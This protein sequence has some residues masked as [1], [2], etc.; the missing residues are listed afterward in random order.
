MR[1]AVLA[2]LLVFLWVMRIE[3]SPLEAGP[4]GHEFPLTLEDGRRI[5]AAGPLLSYEE[6]DRWVQWALSPFFSYRRDTVLDAEEFDVLYPLLTVDRFGGEYKFRWFLMSTLAGGREQDGHR[7]DRFTIFPFLFTQRSP[8]PEENY[9][10]LFPFYGT[11]KKR[12][13]RDRTDFWMFPLYARTQKRDVVT[14]NL[15]YPIFHVRRGESL[16]GWQFWPLVGNETRGVTQRTNNFQEVETVGG[17]RKFFAL[18]PLYFEHDL[19]IGTTNPVTQR[20]FLPFYSLTRSPARDSSTYLWPLFTYTE[21]REKGYWEWDSPWP[22]IVFARGQGKTTDR[23]WPFYS[24]AR[25][26]TSESKFYAWPVYKV[27]RVVAPPLARQ[28]ERVLFYLYS[29]VAETNTL[30][31]TTLRR[32]DLWPLFTTYQDHDGNRRFQALAL[33]EPF[34]PNNKA[35]ERNYSPLWSIYRWEKRAATGASSTSVLWNLYRH[36]RSADTRKCS[37]LFG[38]FQY[39]SA[40]EG[41]RVRL[42][43]LPLTRAPKAAA[44]GAVR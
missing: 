17:H 32:K 44:D 21:D 23:I 28:R 27:N 24:R 26:P 36:E 37:I 9:T 30:R 33:L 12:L 29:N 35:I 15:L 4:F 19:G 16:H 6:R 11:L 43:Y 13:M 10:A 40:P 41:R 18:W 42:F 38:L 20:V 34:L 8:V 2:V 3:A 22:L 5:E 31:E 14:D 25:T 7:V 1:W 39:Q